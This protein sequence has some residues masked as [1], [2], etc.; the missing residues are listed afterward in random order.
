VAATV[1]HIKSNRARAE[2]VVQ[3]SRRFMEGHAAEE[4]IKRSTFA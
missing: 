3:P 2:D 1:Q 4:E